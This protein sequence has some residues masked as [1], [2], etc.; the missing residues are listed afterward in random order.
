MKFGKYPYEVPNDVA[1]LYS[2]VFT[3]YQLV[4]LLTCLD[5]IRLLTFWQWHF[6]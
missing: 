5:F 1:R 3:N 2:E 6:E 4:G